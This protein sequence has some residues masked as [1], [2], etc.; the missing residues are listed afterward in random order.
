MPLHQKDLNGPH[1]DPCTEIIRIFGHEIKDLFHSKNPDLNRVEDT[2]SRFAE[3]LT[4]SDLCYHDNLELDPHVNQIAQWA[5]HLCGFLETQVAQGK[6]KLEESSYFREIV[7]IGHQEGQIGG[8]QPQSKV[9]FIGCG[10]TPVTA[11][12][13]AE[14]FGCQITCV[15]IDTKSLAAAESFLRS[16]SKTSFRFSLPDSQVDLSN[17]THI[18]LTGLVPDKDRYLA[19]IAPSLKPG[20]K[21]IMRYGTGLKS[22]FTFPLPV[23]DT[24]VWQVVRL[25]EPPGNFFNTAFLEKV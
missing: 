6:L 8:I 4:R 20:G 5:A 19:Q 15:D 24:E 2:L 3:A 1:N 18:F 10:S 16:S 9:C 13:L 21:V 11:L 22:L 17:F 12:C 14:A 7:R 25:L 23:I